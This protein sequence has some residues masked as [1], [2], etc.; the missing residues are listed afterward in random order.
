MQRQ[1]NIELLRI[2]AMS[3]ILILHFI[4]HPLEILD[5]NPYA[6]QALVI[7]NICGVNLFVMI[8]GYFGIKGSLQSFIKLFGLIV[9]FSAITLI[10]GV[11]VFDMQLSVARALK[12]FLMPFTV[13]YWFLACYLGL[14]IIAP[15]LNKGLSLLSSGE[16]RRLVV[17]LTLVSIF[18]CWYG[19]NMI[20]PNGYS[21]FHFIYLYILGHF[22]RHD[23]IKGIASSRWLMLC[24]TSMAANITLTFAFDR[25][26]GSFENRYWN[27]NVIDYNNPFV[28][29]ASIAI[30]MCFAKL[31]IP[32][33]SEINSLASAA[34]GCYLLQEGFFGESVYDFQAKF[35]HTYS[36]GITLAMYATS[37][38]AYWLAAYILCRIYNFGYKKF[39]E[40][41][42][43]DMIAS[44]LNLLGR[45]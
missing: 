38:I 29:L 32:Y 11:S 6:Y 22:L 25:Y 26:F 13:Q 8:S 18:S 33:S 2:L 36:G 35:F 45:K 30:F 21:L 42:H 3:F 16:L 37:F 34:L 5:M 20:D 19:K 24:I 17:I 27:E 23:R 15:L 7:T 9:F 31:K 12:T 44:K 39:Q 10:V 28:I 43:P 40:S 41:A 4:I 14:Y 1:S